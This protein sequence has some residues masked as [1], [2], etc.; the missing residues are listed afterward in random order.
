M[1]LLLEHVY[2]TCYYPIEKTTQLAGFFKKKFSRATF[3]NNN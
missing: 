1:K 3:H 2:G